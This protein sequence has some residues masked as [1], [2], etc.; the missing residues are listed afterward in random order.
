M[1]L[2]KLKEYIYVHFFS[3]IRLFKKIKILMNEKKLVNHYADVIEGIKSRNDKIRFAAYVMYDSDYGFDS[4][5]RKMI[6]N[7]S[8]WDPK[9]VIIPDILRGEV[10]SREIYDRTKKFFINLYGEKYVIDGWN[11]EDEYYDYT[12]N[13]DVI[14]F[15]NPYD[16]MAHQYHKIVFAAQKN[17]LPLYVTY[18][19]EVS[20]HF[21]RAR[22]AGDEI[23]SLWRCYT[24]TTYSY[25]DYCK[26]ESRS[27]RNV[28]LVGYSKM[29]NL[30]GYLSKK[31]VLDRKK[32][33]ISPH[34]TVGN[35][36][37]PLS[38][39]LDYYS[40]F[41]KL[42]LMF[43][44]VDFIFRPHPLL[45]VTL[46]NKGIWTWEQVDDYISELTRLGVAYSQGGD[47]FSVFS[48]ADAIINDSG[49][50]TV[51]WLFT[52]KPGCFMRSSK[53]KDRSL[54]TLMR[55]ALSEYTIA[56]SESDIISFVDKVRKEETDQTYHMKEWVKENIAINYPN[57]ADKIIEDLSE[58]LF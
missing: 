23:N 58:Q 52:G 33:L 53:L 48:E 36:E 30:Y 39:F 4:V 20:S 15:N 41:L 16:N 21:T 17:V 56:Y 19:Y 24:D 1:A 9:V 34:H 10:H 51:E 49:S 35:K 12:D 31:S 8:K 2:Q 45:F 22:Q 18:G 32:I 3:F 40:L 11:H 57:V 29:D 26:Y 38:N 50:F 43:P 13:F 28:K 44:E 47:Y 14:Y 5:F 37:L 46:V 54:T 6:L 7:P 25:D 55:K 27:G 42:P